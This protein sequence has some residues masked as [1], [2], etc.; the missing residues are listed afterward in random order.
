[1]TQ[2]KKQ[3][4]L[5]TSLKR[6]FSHISHRR[7]WQ[8]AGLLV[9]MLL[10]AVAEMA[11]LG[12]VIPFLGLLANPSAVDQYPRLQQLLTGLGGNQDNLLLA[13]CIVFIG[14]TL[15]AGLTRFLVLWAGYRISYGLGA[16]IG[17]EVYRRILYQPYLWHVSRNS[18]EV[19][20]AIQK[21]NSVTFGVL[22]QAVQSLAAVILC[23][24]IIGML[25]VIDTKTALIAAIGFTLLYGLI[26]LA[27]RRQIVRNGKVIADSE[28]HRV[29]AVQEGL[30]GI[31]D[32]LIDNTQM[33]YQ[34][35]FSKCDYAM[36][37]AQ[38][39]NSLM[40]A[41]PRIVIEAIGMVLMVGLAY[42]MAGN[43]Q[44]LIG[45]IPI[46]G[47]LAIGAQRLLPQMQLVYASWSSIVGNRRQ[48]DDVLNFLDQPIPAEYAN[49]AI[50]PKSHTVDSGEVPLIALR[51]VSF[52]YKPEAAEAL[53]HI[54]LEIPRGTRIGI[55]G[56]TGSGKST[57]IDLIMGLLEP[58]SGRI[59]IDGEPLTSANHR[60]WHRRIAHVPQFIYLAD[61]SIA[62]NIAFGVPASHIDLT[63]VRDAASK[64]QLTDFIDTLP[65]QYQ[66]SVG[67]RGMRLSGGQRQRIGLARA[68]Y[69][70]ADVLVLDEAT[71]ALDDATEKSVMA[72]IEALGKELT[73]LIIAHR[74]STLRDCDQIVELANASILRTGSYARLLDPHPVW[75]N[76]RTLADAAH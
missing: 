68:L 23:V 74:V 54:N 71:S 37:R 14:V 29:Q 11:T 46:L 62:A 7:R 64:A 49:P 5:L 50:S 6:L 22:V 43:Q 42:G 47:A 24:S 65:Q 25:L 60:A 4:S 63:K 48:M 41:S 32:I 75:V 35:R 8:L 67:E 38:S 34:R 10:G 2:P 72:A 51:E 59:E 30:G 3:T 56:K 58:T 15:A 16:D 66:T 26:S 69:K 31:R 18:S 73:V 1:M 12:T 39:H 19:L 33:T 45:A 70:Q 61:T 27:S 28:T 36:R 17:G 13:A 76:H 55:I 57:L 44:S 20:S 52:R 40:G 53:R 21:V 9:L